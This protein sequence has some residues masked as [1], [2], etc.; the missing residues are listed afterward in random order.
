MKPERSL[1]APDC[2]KTQSE[3]FDGLRV[4]GK[5]LILKEVIPV[6]VSAVEP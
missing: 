5:C 2:V 4:N 6:V 1:A 3:P